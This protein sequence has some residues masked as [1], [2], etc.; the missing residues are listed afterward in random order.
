MQP[1]LSRMVNRIRIRPVLKQQ[2]LHNSSVHAFI[3]VNRKGGEVVEDLIR[4][5][6]HRLISS[7]D[8]MEATTDFNTLTNLTD[9]GLREEALLLQDE[10]SKLRACLQNI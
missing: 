10:I 1:D 4:E 9:P 8:E 2:G 5:I 3:P 7:L 6:A